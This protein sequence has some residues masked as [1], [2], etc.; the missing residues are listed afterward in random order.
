MFSTVVFACLAVL[1][2]AVPAFAQASGGRGNAQILGAEDQSKQISVTFWLNQH[3]KAGFDEMVRADVRPEFAQL[4]SLAHAEGVR[5]AIRAERCKIWLLFASI[6]RRIIC[7]WLP[8]T[9]SIMP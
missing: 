9:N 7:T 8:P 4:P 1:L 6:S 5:S 2:I 3:D